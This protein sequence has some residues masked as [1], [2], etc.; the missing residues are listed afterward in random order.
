MKKKL[1]HK[2]KREIGLVLGLVLMVAIIGLVLHFN[3]KNKIEVLAGAAV[4]LNPEVPTYPGALVLFRDYCQPLSGIGDC[5]TICADKTCFPINQDC[6]QIID[7]EHPCWC[8][9]SP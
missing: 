9:R 4:K 2:E 5:N 3:E 1:T 8:C 6:D 7:Q